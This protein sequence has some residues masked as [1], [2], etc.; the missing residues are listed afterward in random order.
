MPAM[1]SAS[2]RRP[3]ATRPSRARMRD[4]PM[5]SKLCQGIPAIRN[6][7][8]L[9]TSPTTMDV[10]LP[11][12]C[13]VRFL[14]IHEPHPA[15]KTIP[16]KNRLISG[17]GRLMAQRG[18]HLFWFLA[19]YLEVQGVRAEIDLVAPDKLAE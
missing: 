12:D 5:F 18:E 15:R 9:A 17:T 6:L 7:T 19:R 2:A 13:D 4:F 11:P 8:Y 3:A 10:L 16:S 1:R 14:L